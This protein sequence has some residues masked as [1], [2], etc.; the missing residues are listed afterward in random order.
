M[1]PKQSEEKPVCSD[2]GPLGVIECGKSVY[3]SHQN[4]LIQVIVPFSIG[5]LDSFRVVIE[6]GILVIVL[7]GLSKTR[8]DTLIAINHSEKTGLRF[9]SATNVL[10][11]TLAIFPGQVG[12]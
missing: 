2:Y 6:L 3:L 12:I 8:G 5:G 7:K 1:G 10:E 9:L 4:F 11:G